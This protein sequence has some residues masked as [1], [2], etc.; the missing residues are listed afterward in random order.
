MAT[1][2]AD[3]LSLYRN[4]S[5]LKRVNSETTSFTA[6]RIVTSA[7][8][9]SKDYY[10][11]RGLKIDI[12]NPKATAIVIQSFVIEV[13]L[14][15]DEYLA[16]SSIS[17]VYELGLTPG[18]ALRRYLK[19]LLDELVWLEKHEENLS[20]SIRDELGLLQTYLRIV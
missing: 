3:L 2:T 18:Q 13:A 8:V 5:L 19:S 7:N 10:V 11:N 1:A 20:S 6:E 17:N 15:E 9:G 12:S 16:T 4:P 14:S